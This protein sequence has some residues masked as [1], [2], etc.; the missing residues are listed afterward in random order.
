MEFK[1]PRQMF[2]FKGKVVLVTGSS[3]GIGAGIARR[4]GQAGANVAVHYHQQAEAARQVAARVQDLG[5]NSLLVQANVAV[6]AEVQAMIDTV[7]HQFGRLDVLVNN[8]GIYPVT[9]LLE[10]SEAE[11]DQTIDVNLKGVFLCTQAAARAM[12]ETGEG[13]SIINISS[14]EAVN[15]A[16]GHAHY[17]AA[18]A[19]VMMFTMTAALE[20]GPHQIRVNAVGPG[21]INAPQ[22][23]SAWPEGLARWL[24]RVPLGRVGEPEDVADACLFF[25]S[26]ASRWISGTHL[27]VDGGVLTNQIY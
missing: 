23:P 11:W 6:G 10:L 27:V 17:S 3:V 8:A 22:L 13:G 4:F 24:K 9:S 25:A 12:I 19:G 14:I 15:P 20:L 18:K 5:G 16:P 7:L 21:L 26:D 1:E 2:D